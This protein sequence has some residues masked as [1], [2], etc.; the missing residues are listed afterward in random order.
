M[1][2]YPT[3]VHRSPFLT[4]PGNAPAPGMRI[5]KRILP[6]DAADGATDASLPPPPP[7]SPK[8][9]PRPVKNGLLTAVLG[10]SG[11]GKTTLLRALG[12]QVPFSR[13]SSLTGRFDFVGVDRTKISFVPERDAVVA[14]LSV[15]ETL[16]F[17]ARLTGLRGAGPLDD[18]SAR[19]E[20]MLGDVGLL[21]VANSRLGN[22]DKVRGVSGGERR[23]AFIAGRLFAEPA[24]LLVDEPTS[25]L[26]SAGSLAVVSLLRDIGRRGTVVVAAL[27]QPSSALCEIIDEVHLLDRG[28]VI[29]Q[30]TMAG[31][32]SH[33]ERVLKVKCPDNYAPADHFL[34]VLSAD[35]RDPKR[36]AESSARLAVIR[37]AA[38]KPRLDAAMPSDA[39]C[40]AGKVCAFSPAQGCGLSP[41]TWLQQTASPNDAVSLKSQSAF[42]LWVASV[43]GVSYH[44]FIVSAMQRAAASAKEDESFAAERELFAAERGWYPCSSYVVGKALAST[45]SACI[46]ALVFTTVVYWADVGDSFGDY[47][48]ACAVICAMAIALEASGRL[49]GC[50]PVHKSEMVT[51]AMQ[52]VTLL[53]LVSGKQHLWSDS[54]KQNPSDA[55]A[56]TFPSTR[57]RTTLASRRSASPIA[58]LYFCIIKV[59]GQSPSLPPNLPLKR[60]SPR[61]SSRR[62]SAVDFALARSSSILVKHSALKVTYSNIRLEICSKTTLWKSLSH[63]LEQVDAPN[64]PNKVILDDVS[65]SLYP[66][67]VTAIMGASGAG[68]TSLLRVLSGTLRFSS[69]AVLSGKLLLDGIRVDELRTLSRLVEQDDAAWACLSVR[70]TL[71]FA[72]AVHLG[73]SA[74]QTPA[75]AAEAV[76][77]QL[78]LLRVFDRV[79]GDGALGVVEMM[80]LVA[81]NAGRTVAATIH[82]PRGAIA[83]LFDDLILMSAGRVAYSGDASRCLA[84][85]AAIGFPCAAATN[86]TD[87][88]IDVWSGVSL[89]KTNGSRC[90]IES[91][92]SKSKGDVCKEAL[93]CSSDVVLSRK[94]GAETMRAAWAAAPPLVH[95]SVRP[96]QEETAAKPQPLP[97]LTQ[98]QLLCQRSLTNTVRDPIFLRVDLGLSVVVSCYLLLVLRGLERDARGLR[99][100]PGLLYFIMVSHGCRSNAAAIAAANKYQFLFTKERRDYSQRALMASRQLVDFGCNGASI[101]VMLAIVLPS[102]GLCGS[103]ADFVRLVGLYLV[104]AAV[105][106]TMGLAAII[107]GDDDDARTILGSFSQTVL[108]SAAGFFRG[109]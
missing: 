35:A 25:G 104:F 94:D 40:D 103:A 29:F 24:L 99:S 87:H 9:H 11:S 51:V 50:V 41:A 37:A 92:L 36:K 90:G 76:A 59:W 79:V 48:Q 81:K 85:F 4:H 21:G 80:H 3:R 54:S 91:P 86:A 69:K 64:K 49:V 88:F 17:A 93:P 52:I 5:F 16:A 67:G 62:Q 26:D 71:E 44:V 13:N 96:R 8:P 1:D 31:A 30:G 32:L 66:G 45:R 55:Q 6:M 106:W 100:F 43:I 34:D 2:L 105:C 75:E 33:F 74:Q 27:Q 109:F 70:E 78:D 83:G 38:Q 98:L 22:A 58:M 23:R 20:R 53:T 68:K 102:L 14:V 56:S 19:V 89:G 95:S 97:W 73:A 63:R 61:K 12:G 57:P 47:L 72:A 39:Q 77:E 107:V 65:G 108:V 10:P 101:V 7:K 28:H 60:A 15:R 82:T 84:H 46:P 42:G 18:L